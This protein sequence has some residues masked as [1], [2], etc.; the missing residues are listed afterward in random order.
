MS[1]VRRHKV[2]LSRTT[3]P[4]IVPPSTHMN[5]EPERPYNAIVWRQNP[6]TP[7]QRVV[8]FARN[9]EEAQAKIDEEYGKDTIVS[10]WNEDDAN[11]PR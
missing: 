7:G 4:R 6:S 8:V 9:L 1:N 5:Q 2:T 11:A 10:L 3:A